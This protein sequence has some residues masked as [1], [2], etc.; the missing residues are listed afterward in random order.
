M[1]RVATKPQTG[2]DSTRIV[3]YLALLS[4]PALSFPSSAWER[5]PAKLYLARRALQH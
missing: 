1:A 3:A 4:L 2:R 5:N